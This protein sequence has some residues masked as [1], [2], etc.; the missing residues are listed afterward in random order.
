[1]L[2]GIQSKNFQQGWQKKPSKFLIISGH[3]VKNFRPFVKKNGAGL[4]ELLSTCL[5]EQF[6]RYICLK[7]VL[8]FF[9]L[10]R[11]LS[12]KILVFCHFFFNGVAN[13]VIYVSIGTF[14]WK[15]FSIKIFK[16]SILLQTLTGET[17]LIRQAFFSRFEET[18]FYV[19]IDLFWGEFC[20]KKFLCQFWTTSITFSVVKTVI[21]VS[22]G[23]F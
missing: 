16:F 17:S 2:F 19:S 20:E 23:T 12:K 4:P 10:F 7:K 18:A 8:I 9:F 14:R 6:E 1:M 5:Q 22:R 11:T 3:W 15:E 21:Y 13:S